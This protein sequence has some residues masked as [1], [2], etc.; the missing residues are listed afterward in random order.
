MSKE[1]R[2]KR[3]LNINLLGEADKVYAS[4]KQDVISKKYV[5]KPTDFHSLMPKLKVKVGDVVKAGSPLFF[6]KSNEK[7]NF[8][9]PVSGKVSDIIRGQKR[10]ILE[11]VVDADDNI[12]YEKFNISSHKDLSRE[13]IIDNMLKGGV[14]PFIRQKPYDVIASPTDMPKAIFISAFKSAPLSIDNDFALYGMEELFQKGLDY[15]AKLTKGKTHLNIDGNTNVSKVFGS[16]KGV[17]INKFSGPHPAGNVGIQIHHL[18]PIN[19][20]DI[21]WYLE[22]QDVIAIARLFTQ[23]KYDVSRIVA[24]AGSQVEKPR[25]HRT[26]SGSSV[27]N[28]LIDN[29][30]EGDNR[31]ISGDVLTGSRINLNGNL[32]FYDT[33]ISVIPEG[34][35]QEFLGW[36]LPGLDK[37]SASKTFFSWLNPSKKYTVS[38]NMHGEERAYVVT[39]DYEK[40]LPMNIFPLQLIKA[41][42]IE[43]IELMENLGMYE[44]SPEDFA[45]CEFICTSKIEVQAIIR[46]GLDLLRIENS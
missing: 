46:E 33:T 5:L 36:I 41:I 11:V 16:C 7:I 15:I 23:G 19:K 21:I 28:L 4:V 8:C 20:G 45:L 14:W 18:D 31:I 37:F 13:Q 9:S 24:L 27:S 30:N 22:P 29:L 34:N 12:I 42:M 39:G 35:Q 32:G 2:L 6:N 43:D 38:S 25:Y 44:V 40:V 3:G 10:K 1:I 17:V 26:I